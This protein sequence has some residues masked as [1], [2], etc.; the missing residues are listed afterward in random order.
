MPGFSGHRSL[1]A[2]ATHP[3]VDQP[4]IVL[5][6]DLG[7]QAELLHRA[8]PRALHQDVRSADQLRTLARS[9]VLVRSAV[10]SVRPRSIPAFA[11]SIPSS[12]PIEMGRTMRTTSAPRSANIR[13]ACSSGLWLHFNDPDTRQRPAVHSAGGF[14]LHDHPRAV[15]VGTDSVR[16]GSVRKS[17]GSTR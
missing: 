9:S 8:G 17:A 6:A 16:A 5:Q 10:S 1:L 12:A 7:A 2:P 13:P 14:V 11:S 15:G 3:A 4:R